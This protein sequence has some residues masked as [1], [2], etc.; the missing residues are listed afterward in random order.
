M[1]SRT[2]ARVEPELL[3]IVDVDDN[4]V[5]VAQKQQIHASRLYHRQVF[6]LVVDASKSAL[7][8]Q[9]SDSRRFDPG[10]WTASASGHVAVGETYLSA[11]RRELREEL[12]LDPEQMQFI[13]KVLACCE[14][15]GELCGGPS[16]I[17]VARMDTLIEAIPLQASEVKRVDWIT[18]ADLTRV[19]RADGTFWLR[20]GRMRIADEFA[21]VLPVFL[22]HLEP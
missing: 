8:Q 11:A 22:R 1:R 13:G 17:F 10:R 12:G 18:H 19:T 2:A 7:L 3:E 14:V 20:G 16:A 4:V 5:G 6:V 21:V 9:R 15:E